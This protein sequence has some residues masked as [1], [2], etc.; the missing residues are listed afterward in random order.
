M[1]IV[2][3]D[4]CTEPGSLALLREGNLPEIEELPA[5][6]HS[7]T[8]HEKILRLLSRHGL[9]TQDISGY[10]VASGPGAFTAVRIGLTAV[11]GL[12]EAHGKPMVTLSTLEMLAAAAQADR[13][14]RSPALLAPL[15][16]ARRGQVFG[17]VYR[18]EGEQCF[19]V[20]PEQVCSLP[21]FLQQIQAAGL[22]DLRFCGT[23]LGLF[24]EQIREAGWNGG[25]LLELPPLLAGVL[26]QTTLRRLQDGRGVSALLAEANYVRASDAELFWK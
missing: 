19:P 20:I 12:A 3:V 17:A 9:T 13:R 7:T 1:R 25:S 18:I 10:G 14:D 6:W 8:L 11:K 5:G 2:A 4:T 26:A 24:W 16:V 15:M 21:L 22:E 23:H